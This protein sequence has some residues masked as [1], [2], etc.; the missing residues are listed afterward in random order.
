MGL[1]SFFSLAEKVELG[2]SGKQ[3]AKYPGAAIVAFIV[4]WCYDHGKMPD[5]VWKEYR[6]NPDNFRLLAAY[7]NYQAAKEREEIEK[8]KKK[9]G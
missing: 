3:V 8:A 5:R 9:Q 1:I 6:R 2:A 7:G 4:K